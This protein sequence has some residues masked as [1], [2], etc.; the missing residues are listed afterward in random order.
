MNI[1]K[2]SKQNHLYTQEIA[3]RLLLFPMFPLV[4]VSKYKLF[5]FSMINF[6]EVT[7]KNVRDKGF[8]I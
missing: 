7:R 2:V 1:S 8:N 3:S 6:V 4:S 5:T